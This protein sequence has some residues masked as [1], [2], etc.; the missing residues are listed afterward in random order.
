MLHMHCSIDDNSYNN[1]VRCLS[2]ICIKVHGEITIKKLKNKNKTAFVY[3]HE[4]SSQ[5]PFL[6]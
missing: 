2:D 1:K 3:P 4:F 6:K 5:S